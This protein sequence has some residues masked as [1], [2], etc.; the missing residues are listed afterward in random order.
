MPPGSQDVPGGPSGAPADPGTGPAPEPGTEPTADTGAGRGRPTTKPA[1]PV[2]DA[3]QLDASN[4][5]SLSGTRRGNSVSLIL[6][7][8]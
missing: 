4:A 5:G 3:S 1:A 8:D 2:A 6:P 7:W